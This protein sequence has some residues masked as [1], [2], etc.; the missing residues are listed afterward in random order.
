MRPSIVV[1]PTK[2]PGVA[3]SIHLS[4]CSPS[5]LFLTPTYTPET[6]NITKI[7]NMP[8]TKRANAEC[9]TLG[10]TKTTPINI[11]ASEV[12]AR[13]QLCTTCK[14]AGHESKAKEPQKATQATSNIRLNSAYTKRRD[15]ACRENPDHDL[16]AGIQKA[17][18]DSQNQQ[19]KQV[20]VIQSLPS[21]H[22]RRQ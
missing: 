17:L 10:C 12:E 13:P 20:Y 18:E 19:P 21:S 2:R 14:I 22:S 6:S 1:Q 5:D 8:T 16:K 9:T 15:V 7:I 4:L 3:I 11:L